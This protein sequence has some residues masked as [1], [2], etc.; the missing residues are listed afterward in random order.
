[1]V[2]VMTVHG[3][4]VISASLGRACLLLCSVQGAYS[5]LVGCGRLYMCFSC[6][7]LNFGSCNQ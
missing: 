4:V 1:M 2:I 7:I 3:M 6:A 5:T